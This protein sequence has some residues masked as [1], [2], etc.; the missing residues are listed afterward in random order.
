MSL[1]STA[2]HP[3]A[4][5]FPRGLPGPALRALATARIRSMADVANRTLADVAALHGMGPKAIR[6]LADGL[7]LQGLKFRDG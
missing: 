2:S 1:K 5:A 3:N 6:I 7:A 4:S